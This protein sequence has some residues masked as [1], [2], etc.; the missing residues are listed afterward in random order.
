M[1][2][3]A[4]QWSSRRKS[5]VASSAPASGLKAQAA[6]HGHELRQRS[7]THLSHHPSTVFL[8]GEFADTELTAN[9]LVQLAPNHQRH[10]FPFATA[11]R[12][13][14]ITKRLE[15]RLLLEAQS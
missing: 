8:N 2:G 7:R 6:R 3:R 9:L 10:Y 13:V 15:V 11:E 5:A 14:T 1:A 4:E 12:L